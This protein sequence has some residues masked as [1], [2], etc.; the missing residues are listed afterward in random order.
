MKLLFEVNQNE[1]LVKERIRN[2]K[3]VKVRIER[4]TKTNFLIAYSFKFCMISGNGHPT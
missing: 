4:K 2:V 1:K 3:L